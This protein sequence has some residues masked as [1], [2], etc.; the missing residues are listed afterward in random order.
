MVK[1]AVTDYKAKHGT[2]FGHL[3]DN[4]FDR[5]LHSVKL[6]ASQWPSGLKTTFN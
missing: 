2:I 5:P 4:P 6:E 1:C 3:Y